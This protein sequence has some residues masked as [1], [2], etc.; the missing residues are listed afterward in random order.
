MFMPHN[1]MSFMTNKCPCSWTPAMRQGTF[2]DAWWAESYNLRE[3]PQV[4]FL[5]RQ[6][7]CCDK[8]VFV[9]T[10]VCLSRQK[11]C[12]D[13]IMFVVDFLNLFFPRAKRFV[14]T[15]ICFRNKTC[16]HKNTFVA[17]KDVF[18]RDKNYTCGSSR[19]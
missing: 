12:R 13:K 15:N 14:A 17:T 9:A 18:C 19:Q 11:L 6:K 1:H 10:K 8:H 4:S 7:F 3:P 16:H 5:P 2:V